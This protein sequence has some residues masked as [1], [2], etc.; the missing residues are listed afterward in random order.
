[1]IVIRQ[2]LARI[3]KVLLLVHVTLVTRATAKPV[4]LVSC[5]NLL[6]TKSI[7]IAC[8]VNLTLSS[9]KKKTL[10]SNYTSMIN[11]RNMIKKKKWKC[12]WELEAHWLQVGAAGKVSPNWSHETMIF[13]SSSCFS[14][15][16]CL[17]SGKRTINDFSS[18]QL[19]IDSKAAIP[20]NNI[21]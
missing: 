17:G 4:A 7:W 10:A 1:M 12:N 13:H 6:G 9:L 5:L 2:L 11:A 21:T 8:V 3:P 14:N 19:T 15:K 16:Y 20:H 18:E